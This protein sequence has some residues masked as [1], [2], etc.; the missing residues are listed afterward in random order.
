M[1]IDIPP[2]QSAALEI[3]LYALLCSLPIFAVFWLEE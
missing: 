3:L 1:F 2:V